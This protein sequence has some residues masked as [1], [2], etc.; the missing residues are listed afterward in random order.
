MK[1]PFP[2]AIS[3]AALL[4][5]CSTISPKEEAL[6]FPMPPTAAKLAA[7]K[8]QLSPEATPVPKDEQTLLFEQYMEAKFLSAT[9]PEKACPVWSEISR[10]PSFPLNHVAR[11]HA[12]ETCPTGEE[13]PFP[14]AEVLATTPEPWLT[15]MLARKTLARAIRL[16]DKTWEMKLSFDVARHEKT[17]STQIR[18]LERTIAL[19]TDSGDK[20]MLEKATGRLYQLAPR[21]IP[22]PPSELH[23]TVALDHRRAREFDKALAYFEKVLAS[24]S[25]PD[26]EKIKALDGIRTTYKLQNETQKFI[27]ATRRY[28]DFARKKFFE[29]AQ[30]KSNRAA[31]YARY[32]DA[33]LTLA[34]AVWTDNSPSEARTILTQ[35]EKDLKGRHPVDES[36]LIRARIEEEAGRFEE[37]VHIL[38]EIDPKSLAANR[39]FRQK[40]NWYRAWN[41]R[42]TR[43]LSE[44]AFLLEH[45]IKDSDNPNLVMRERFWLGRTLK[46]SGQI[47]RST[48]EFEWLIQND[49]IGYY[50]ALSYRELGRP[51]PPLPV[52]PAR[53]PASEDDEFFTREERLTYEW[54]IAVEENDLAKRL[55]DT[56]PL[57][58]RSGF[59]EPQAFAYLRSY[60]R[61]GDYL[62]LFVRLSELSPEVRRH[63]VESQPELIFPMKWKSEIEKSASKFGVAP[64]LVYS[65]IRQES[66]FNPLARSHADAFGLMQLIPDAAKKAEAKTGVK[67]ATHEDLYKPEINIPAGT[68]FLR[69]VLD[70][71]QGKFIPAVASYNASEKAVRGWLKTRDRSEP[72]QFIEDVPY[73]ETR[74]YLKLVMRNYVFYSRLNSGQAP[75]AFPEWCLDGLQDIKL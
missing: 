48:A 29:G 52:A 8:L 21:K 15:E 73:E 68:A 46:D 60:A 66:S 49:P 22:N 72:L 26:T 40:V 54:L 70:H 25:I 39:A 69:G 1:F 56:I 67:L 5:A 71:W 23:L 38:G 41:M 62:S 14:L 75:I 35:V 47:E 57:S 65:I 13:D 18:L 19:A 17:Q 32:L 74:G 63:L 33:R 42:K 36:I 43:R 30:S 50:G 45:L 44:A 12:I 59:S 27:Q 53:A 31:L 3:A 20:A 7:S 58:R 4:W 11:L 16:G 10:H 9:E 61:A 28:T 2:A 55:L 64:E 24:P 6:Y 34:R 51:I 37:T